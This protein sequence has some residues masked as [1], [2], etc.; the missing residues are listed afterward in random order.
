MELSKRLSAVASLVTEGASVADIGTD[1]GY[2]PIYLIQQHIAKKVI[3]ADIN[4]G[5]LSRAAIHISG[6]KSVGDYIETRLSDGLSNISAGEV[7][8][9]IAAGMGGGLVIKILTE[10]KAVVDSLSHI[11]LQPQSEIEKVRWFLH[12]QNLKIIRE[13]MIEEDGK[14]YPIMEAMHG[15]PEEYRDIDFLFGKLLLKERHPVLKEYLR[16]ELRIKEEICMHLK[17][18]NTA[19]A[20]ERIDE[21]LV[22]LSK[23]EEA[24]QYFNQEG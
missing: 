9:M 4:K 6:H 20:T 7:D 13:D 18:A 8:T 16:K 24:Y 12:E 23:I 15:K 11:I 19:Q 21:I 3:A 22:E 5:P 1:H 10:G 17:K 2:I 14:Y